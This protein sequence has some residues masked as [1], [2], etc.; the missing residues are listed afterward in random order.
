VQWVFFAKIG[1][2][3]AGNL[4]PAGAGGADKEVALRD[5][6]SSGYG[7]RAFLNSFNKL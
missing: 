5:V 7:R 1:K 2:S 6:N 3:S 4:N